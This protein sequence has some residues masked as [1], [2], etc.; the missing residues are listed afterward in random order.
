MTNGLIFSNQCSVCKE[1]VCTWCFHN[2]KWLQLEDNNFSTLDVIP[3][4]DDIIEYSFNL[5][6]DIYYV[7]C[8]NCREYFINNFSRLLSD[9][10]LPY[11]HSA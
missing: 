10:L 11:L 9:G 3:N 7:C 4:C 2:G 6:S 5:T 1:Y 8:E